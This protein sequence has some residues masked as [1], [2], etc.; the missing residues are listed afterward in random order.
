MS[1]LAAYYKPEEVKGRTVVVLRN[2]KP[3][4]F[5]GVKSEGMVMCAQQG[6]KD[7]AKFTLLTV[8][9][10]K[11]QP[12]QAPPGVEVGHDAWQWLC[13]VCAAKCG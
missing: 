10:A 1:G 4:K 11:G 3:S 7:G 2:L 6:G 13:A 5:Q 8:G 9:D 12:C